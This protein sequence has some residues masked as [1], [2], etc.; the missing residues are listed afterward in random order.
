MHRGYAITRSFPPLRIFEFHDENRASREKA[1]E[2]RN[3]SWLRTP[4]LWT[5]AEVPNFP[6]FLTTS[7][8]VVCRILV[9]PLLP[10]RLQ[11]AALR[12]A[13]FL[14]LSFTFLPSFRPPVAR[15]ATIRL[16]RE[17]ADVPSQ[18]MSTICV[19]HGHGSSEKARQQTY[20][21]SLPRFVR[22]LPRSY[23]L[24]EK[25]IKAWRDMKKRYA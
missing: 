13:I 18:V 20:N 10:H 15:H 23:R 9:P 3:P 5:S 12:L 22:I 16:L 21:A 24:V 8:R 19:S 7:L 6:L 25:R 11:R 14:F 1:R 17:P 4:R 2:K